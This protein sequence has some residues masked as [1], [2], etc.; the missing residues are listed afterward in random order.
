[1]TYYRPDT[2]RREAAR[3]GLGLE[4]APNVTAAYRSVW[5]ASGK[6]LPEHQ[7]WIVVRLL[8]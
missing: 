2:L 4:V 5:E 1:V 3:H 8:A 7:D 6:L